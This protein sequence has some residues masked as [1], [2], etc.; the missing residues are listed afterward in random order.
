M[1]GLMFST[2]YIFAHLL[3]K[4][5]LINSHQEMVFGFHFK[6]LFTNFRFF[7]F[8]FLA[9]FLTSFH[10]CNGIVFVQFYSQ[11][12]IWLSQ[13]PNFILNRKV[14]KKKQTFAAFELCSFSIYLLRTRF[15]C[16]SW[17]S[18]A[19]YAI[20]IAFL[21][22]YKFKIRNIYFQLNYLLT[23]ESIRART[24]FSSGTDFW[25]TAARDFFS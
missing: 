2:I 20:Q 5:H 3:P 8:F 25:P 9:C 6:L 24:L 21:K 11:C 17:P 4:N 23:M 19:I 15:L 12:L 10:R 1:P 16:W 18:T 7:L 14:T 22:E 13:T